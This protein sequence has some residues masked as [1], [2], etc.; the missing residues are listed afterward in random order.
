MDSNERDPRGGL[1]GVTERYVA[2][3]IVAGD[4]RRRVLAAALAVAALSIVLFWG[5]LDPWGSR[6]RAAADEAR[7]AAQTAVEARAE[8]TGAP[9]AETAERAIDEVVARV[10]AES[11]SGRAGSSGVIA[12]GEVGVA[13]GL[14]LVLLLLWLRRLGA[15]EHEAVHHAFKIAR[16]R[17]L[18][19]AAYNELAMRQVLSV[20]THHDERPRRA[21][22]IGLLALLAAP[23]AWLAV[24]SGVEVAAAWRADEVSSNALALGAALRLLLVAAAVLLT[25]AALRDQVKLE[26]EWEAARAA[27]PPDHDQR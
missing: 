24:L 21:T 2:A 4:R 17:D 22:A 11:R 27:I 1:E 7:A 14:A 23:A 10:L 5:D 20:P 19:V 13:T 26:R 18:L 16:R 15:R 12:P 25:L 6:A 3:A 8:R 9:Q